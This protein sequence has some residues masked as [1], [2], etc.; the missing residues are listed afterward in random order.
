MVRPQKHRTVADMPG[1][2]YFKPAGIPLRQIEEVELPV[3]EYEAV[4]LKDMEGMEQEECA[5]HMGISRPTFQRVLSKARRHIAEAITQGKALRINGGSFVIKSAG[6]EKHG[7]HHHRR[8]AKNNQ[9][10]SQ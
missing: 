5:R 7:R 8:G 6:I 9:A 4:R 1:V 3:E 10:D 2:V